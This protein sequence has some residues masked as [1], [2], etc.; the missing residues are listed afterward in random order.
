M[1]S[2]HAYNPKAQAR[3]AFLEL[4]P[5]L[6]RFLDFERWGFQPVFS[7]EILI[8]A[9]FGTCHALMYQSKYCKVR[10]LVRADISTPDTYSAYGRLH[11]PVDRNSMLWDGEECYCWHHG[12]PAAQFLEG[13]SPHDAHEIVPPCIKRLSDQYQLDKWPWEEY[14]ARYAAAIWGQYGQRFFDL[15]DVRQTTLWNSYLAYCQEYYGET[16][17]FN[18]PC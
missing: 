17:R 5:L 16:F 2:N 13:I 10:F 11:A 6:E 9:P 7:G 14:L 4:K 15:Y 12:L 1:N 3:Q 18:K 8:P